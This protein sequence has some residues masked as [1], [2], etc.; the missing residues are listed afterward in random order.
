M[1]KSQRDRHAERP[2]TLSS[3]TVIWNSVVPALGVALMLGA[4]VVPALAIAAAVSLVIA[5]AFVAG[6]RG[7][8]S[9]RPVHGRAA[10]RR[11]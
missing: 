6:S 4:S 8:R 1:N 7:D 5:V 9:L 10:P 3:W 2:W 11:A